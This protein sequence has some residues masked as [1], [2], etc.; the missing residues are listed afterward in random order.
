MDY[1]LII[2]QQ[3]CNKFIKQEPIFTGFFNICFSID[4]LLALHI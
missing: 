1:Y 2:I 3:K 4:K